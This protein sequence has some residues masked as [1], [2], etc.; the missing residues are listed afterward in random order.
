MSLGL[1][2]IRT[3]STVSELDGLYADEANDLLEMKRES[4]R[5]DDYRGLITT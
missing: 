5:Y 1:V 4:A 3:H 2:E